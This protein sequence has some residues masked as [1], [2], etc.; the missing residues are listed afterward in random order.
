M[1][2]IFLTLVL[3]IAFS[4]NLFAQVRHVDEFYYYRGDKIELPVNKSHFVVY[5]NPG[6]R[7]FPAELTAL[8]TLYLSERNSQPGFACRVQAP[9]D[10]FLQN[11]DY[12][13]AIPSVRTV[14][15]VLGDGKEAVM[16]SNLLYVKLN[17]GGDA[18][19]LEE[20]AGRL[21]AV[22]LWERDPVL[23]WYTLRNENRGLTSVEVANA[24][25]ETGLFKDVD[26]GF[27]FRFRNHEA[28][29]SDSLFEAEQWSMENIHACRAWNV[30]T[31][32]P[33]VNVAIVDAGIRES[34][35]E[36]SQH[37][38]VFS[39][40][41]SNDNPFVV[42]EFHGTHVGGI[43]FSGHND[44]AIAGVAPDVGAINLRVNTYLHDNI[45]AEFA[46][47]ITMAVEH[48]ARVVN[49]SWGDQ[50][51]AQWAQPLHSQML[52]DAIDNA[53]DNNVL[54]V[55]AS[56]NYGSVPS[57]Q[58]DYPA[59]YRKEILVVGATN[60]DDYRAYF[61][62]HGPQLDLVAPG[63]DIYSATNRTDASYGHASGTS[64]AAPH[65]TGVAGLIFSKRPDLTAQQVHDIINATA[66][67]V[68][69][70]YY[71]YEVDP[72]HPSGTWNKQV[73]HGLL[74]ASRALKQ[75][76]LYQYSDLM[77]RDSVGDDGTA[78]SNVRYMWN[79]PDIW[80]EDRQ[81]NVV[82]NPIAGVTYYVCVRIT[83]NSDIA[84]SGN[85]RLFLNWS[86]ASSALRWNRSWMGSTMFLCGDGPHPQGGFI[87]SPFGVSVPSIGAHSET[88]VRVRWLVPAAED[89][90]QCTQFPA[91][92]WH[93]C[94]LAR[95]HDGENIIG[96]NLSDVDMVSFVCNN[97]N[98]AL[99]NVSLLNSSYTSAVVAVANPYREAQKFR[100]LLRAKPTDLGGLLFNYA[101]VYLRLDDD[102]LDSWMQ[103]GAVCY[104][105]RYLGDNLFHVASNR[106]SLEYIP[107]YPGKH[108]TV[109]AFVKFY[110]IDTPETVFE[111]DFMQEDYN[112]NLLGGE[113]YV[114][115]KD[116]GMAVRATALED[117]TVLAGETTVFRAVEHDGDAQY[118]WR[119]V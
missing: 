33:S 28:C 30:T 63:E 50:N 105:G 109:E 74:D 27:T 88:V 71:Y 64:M 25:W 10:D 32:D 92:L 2:K 4:C 59:D 55:F 41:V 48:G 112:G 14:E 26:P 118:V 117:Q 103:S 66:Q 95:V 68:H 101:N 51:H 1:K 76:I 31:G 80:L 9:Y 87:G 104:G 114:A 96:E 53:I 91:K 73:G 111:F 65:V 119:T 44:Y 106:F 36:F 15:Y 54:L 35:Q 46:K 38:F 22:V 56:G 23:N 67:K 77:I 16:V 49:N 97:N 100:L 43:I 40:D 3:C 45:S 52:E 102:L 5:L 89:Y 113:R 110:A 84:S 24:M 18:A 8:D 90:A 99:K 93:F 17:D 21:G 107:M 81:G 60:R 108:H 69:P 6:V 12:L 116:R 70:R 72:S 78:P 20:V 57:H 58:I 39:Y 115:V 85:E 79:S 37:G 94:L 47:A 61:S 62:S 11:M 34:H 13:L 29:V 83:N 86:K 98:V 82:V 42:G 19:S 7:E 75:A